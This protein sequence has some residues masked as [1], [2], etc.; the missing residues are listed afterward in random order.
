M[1]LEAAKALS[2]MPPIATWDK[3]TNQRI[4]TLHPLIKNLV[5]KIVNECYDIGIKIRITSDGHLRTFD[6]Q[7]ELYGHSRTSEQLKAKGINPEYA[8]PNETWKTNAIGGESFHNYG[9]AVDIV[10]I[11]GKDLV[12]IP[13]HKVVEIFKKYGFEWGGDWKGKKKDNPHFQITF[14][15]TIKQLQ[16]M[17]NN[18]QIDGKG[19]IKFS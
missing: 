18:H 16:E 1:G 19:Y 2:N 12:W 6:K 7:N 10:T 17:Y 5:A 4:E 11:A 14:D 15:Y 3:F 8:K 13:S 9:L